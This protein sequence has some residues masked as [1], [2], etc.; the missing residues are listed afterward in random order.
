MSVI[1]ESNHLMAY[2]GFLWIGIYAGQSVEPE[3]NDL[4]AFTAVRLFRLIGIGIYD[5]AHL[6]LAKNKIFFGK[7]T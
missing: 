1:P 2:I 4:S 6:A 3:S 7:K 5:P